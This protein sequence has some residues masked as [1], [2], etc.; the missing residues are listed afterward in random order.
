MTRIGRADLAADREAAAALLR[1]GKLVAFPT[2][3]VYGLGA[4]AT[5]GAAVAAIF[6]AKQRPAFNPLIAHLAAVDAV[7]EFAVWNDAARALAQAFW[8][9]ALTLVLPRRDDC[10]IAL[11]ASAGLDSVALRVPSHPDAH[12]LLASVDRPIAAPSANRSGR[13]S[14]TTAAHVR[15]ELGEDVDMILD[16]GPCE[17]GLESTVVGFRNDQ[18]VLLRPGGIAMEQLEAVT[19]ALEMVEEGAAPS[20][21]GQLASHYAPAKPLRLN[22][23]EAV[24]DEILMGFGTAF[25]PATNL[26]PAGDLIEAAANLFALLRRLDRAPGRGIAVAPIPETGL[27]RAINDRLRRAAAPRS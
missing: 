14:P 6:A 13:I 9:G 18:P 7:G 16:G 3:T 19:G 24:G 22:A 8:P 23:T 20:S 11:I 25:D 12:A 17:I 27:G 5:N 15:D 26:S 21:P 2:E 1:A 10:A 4:D